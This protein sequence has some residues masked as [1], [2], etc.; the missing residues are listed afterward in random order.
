MT[1][2]ESLLALVQDNP[3]KTLFIEPAPGGYRH[4][5][6]RQFLADVD[7]ARQALQHHGIGHGRCIATWLPNWSSAYAWQFA[8]S[9]VGAHVIG[10]NTRY[11]IAEVAHV[12]HK[13][14]PAVIV[15]AHDFQ[16]LDLTGRARA[17]VAADAAAAIPAVVPVPAPG[18][19]GPENP[20]GY[21]LGG[22]V[23][24]VPDGAVPDAAWSPAVPVEA[25]VLSV[26]FT[27]SG[28]TGMPK[29]AAHNEAGVIRHALADA[30]RIG[31]A[32]TDVL[33]GALPFSGVFGFSSSM[34]AIFGGAA[35][36]LHP[37]FDEH[38]LV[39]AMAE[40]KATHFVGAD[41]M[42]SRIAAA[43]TATRADLGSWKWI[44]IAD[45]QGQS[46]DLAAWASR[47]FGT[48]TVGVYGSSELFALT[49]FWTPETDVQRRWGGGGYPVSAE[50][51]VRIADPFT[52]QI[53][54]PSAE[55]ELQ[56][57]G[58]N[59]VN[60]YLGDDGEGAAAFTR[61]GWFRSGDLGTIGEDGGFVYICRM[62]DVLRLKGFL[63]DPAEI[64]QRLMEHPSVGTAKVV[65]LQGA[66]GQMQAIGF[67]TLDPAAGVAGVTGEAGAGVAG[68]ELQA[69]CK[70][71]LARFKVPATVHIIDEMPTTAGTN[72][73]KIRAATLRDWARER[74]S[75][76]ADS[77]QPLPARSPET[78]AELEKAQ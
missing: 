41:D 65:G 12:L 36:L 61:D 40:H 22:G 6:R 26:A 19:T 46:R 18:K 42:I 39:H 37:V 58:P 15:M 72:G 38:E 32:G 49:A 25:D 20:A 47:E 59:V 74:S 78:T 8:A 54:D 64:E 69:W 52:E 2:Y 30:A 62:G 13:A 14:K 70:A 17:A 55:G 68:E 35:I 10:I 48:E 50:I 29:L 56:F 28:S 60:A 3:G 45:F 44:G 33:V 24:A 66:D 51:K 31:F 5:T 11:N 23:W 16:R 71:T 76:G 57:Q 63:V 77:A 1:L 4:L 27:T 43:W 73:T 9:A 34:A 53:L 21:D 75:I 67:V 7:A